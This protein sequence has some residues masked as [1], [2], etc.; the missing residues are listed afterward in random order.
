MQIAEKPLTPNNNLSTT[1]TKVYSSETDDNSKHGPSKN[2]TGPPVYY[3][4]NHELFEAKEESAAASRAQVKTFS[5]SLH[6]TRSS[7]T[8]ET[9]S[10]FSRADMQ[11]RAE[12]ICTNHPR[13][14]KAAVNQEQQ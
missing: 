6:F 9:F 2:I 8:K 10:D 7:F 12:N 5:K 11:K 3:P 14:L 4:P 1:T 13:N